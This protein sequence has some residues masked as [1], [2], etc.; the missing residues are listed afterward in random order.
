M[1]LLSRA[2]SRAAVEA[3]NK[4]L[5]KPK[6]GDGSTVH[7][8]KLML[9]IGIVCTSV[10]LVP[11]GY[12][13]LVEKDLLGI[14]FALFALLSSSLI[15]AF[16]NQR[17]YYDTEGFTAKSFCGIRRRFSYSD[18]EC[19]IGEIPHDL[20]KVMAD[21]ECDDVDFLIEYLTAAASEDIRLKA[22]G[23][24]ILI[25]KSA[26][27]GLEF[28]AF[29]QKQYKAVNGGRPIPDKKKTTKCDAIFNGNVKNATSQIVIYA[30]ILVIWLG[31]FI[32]IP[33]T[34]V[35]TEMDELEFK[36]VTVRGYEKDEEY[37]YLNIDGFEDDIYIRGYTEIFEDTNAFLTLL[38]NGEQIEI[39]YDSF[40]DDGITE[41]RIE[42]VRDKNSG[43]LTT[44]EDYHE[45]YQKD[46]KKI[47]LLFA[48]LILVWIAYIA[49]TIYVGRNPHKF[50]K[51]FV[52][53]FFKEGT[54]KL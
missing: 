3:V 8:P 22:G 48:V 34:N 49:F 50:S 15:V 43:V 18:I 26:V 46:V 16:V 28:L 25:D 27:G 45:F 11:A 5:Q 31:M 4:E 10:F 37:L 30:V 6:K 52:H 17:I 32:M 38:D 12:L 44:P 14:A 21:E 35:P 23:R 54:I 24:K 51:K 2:L 20:D 7:L 29:A 19:S 36:T 9:I 40:T 41:H 53:I 13:L 33:I 47:M 1:N 42:Y 39:G